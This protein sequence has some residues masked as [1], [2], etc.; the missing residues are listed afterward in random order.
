MNYN[1]IPMEI[2]NQLRGEFP[3]NSW[4]H[5]KIRMLEDERSLKIKTTFGRIKTYE[6]ICALLL[7]EIML[8]MTL[9]L[10][11]SVIGRFVD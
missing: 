4:L 3:T 1:C 8:L 9:M 6:I 5:R 7:S 10:W 11:Q 2:I